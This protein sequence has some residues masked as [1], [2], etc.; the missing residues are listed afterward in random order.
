M[1]ENDW[2]TRQYRKLTVWSTC[3]D[4]TP[5]KIV[6]L[7]E[8]LDHGFIALSEPGSHEQSEAEI[9]HVH[10]KPVLGGALH[11]HHCGSG[12]VTTLNSPVSEN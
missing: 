9:R 6:E 3:D 7:L 12:V 2:M 4:L 1:M 11:M 5:A 8:H 10:E